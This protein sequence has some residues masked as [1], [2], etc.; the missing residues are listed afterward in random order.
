MKPAIARFEILNDMDPFRVDDMDI[1]SNLLYINDNKKKLAQLATKTTKINKYHP[2]SYCVV[3]NY[4]SIRKDHTK[5][6]VY[7]Q[8]AIRK[9]PSY[10]AAWVLMGHEFGELKNTK[11]ALHSYHRAT[12]M[13]T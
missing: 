10:L 5:A 2:E 1:H 12:G 11:A 13:N 3:A 9:D 8:R 6:I 4:Y 7:F